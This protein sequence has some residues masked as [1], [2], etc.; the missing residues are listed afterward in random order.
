MRRYKVLDA[1]T[2]VERNPARAAFQPSPACGRA[3]ARLDFHDGVDA[4]GN[5]LRPVVIRPRSFADIKVGNA[6]LHKERNT[7]RCRRSSCFR[8][9]DVYTVHIEHTISRIGVRA[10]L[11]VFQNL[12]RTFLRLGIRPCLT[13]AVPCDRRFGL[14][15]IVLREVP[16][17]DDGA[18]VL[19]IGKARGVAAIL[20]DLHGFLVVR[21]SLQPFVAE[22]VSVLCAEQISGMVGDGI[23]HARIFAEVRRDC[24][25]AAVRVLLLRL[26]GVLA[27]SV[28]CRTAPCVAGEGAFHTEHIICVLRQFGFAVAGFE[29]KLRH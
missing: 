25:V 22:L 16:P 26:L 21:A 20:D 8:C 5:E 18:E 14:L 12:E 29:D 2:K 19:H 17:L 28:P 24:F 7:S 9:V 6:D 23:L 1:G 10:L 11:G 4:D 3:F 13:D 15:H 27:L